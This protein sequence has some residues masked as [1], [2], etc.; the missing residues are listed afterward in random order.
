[1][2]YQVKGLEVYGDLYSVAS[3]PLFHF[4]VDTALFFIKSNDY[5]IFKVTPNKVEHSFHFVFPLINALPADFVSNAAYKGKRFQYLKDHKDAIYGIGN[6]FLVG[7]NLTFKVTNSN[8]VTEKQSSMIYNLKSGTIIGLGH[9]TTDELSYFLPVADHKMLNYTGFVASDGEY[10]YSSFPSMTM[11]NA[12]EENKGKN[13]SYNKVLA[14]Y[15]SNGKNVDNPVIVQI[16][17]KNQ[18]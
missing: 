1:M 11:F 13:I 16:K 7:D 3:G 10:V 4:G 14:D 8:L 15:F 9:I 17:L 2:P 5:S 12:H 6:C 18:L